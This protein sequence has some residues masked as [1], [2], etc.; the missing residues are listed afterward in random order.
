M[1]ATSAMALGRFE[2]LPLQRTSSAP[3]VSYSGPAAQSICCRSPYSRSAASAKAMSCCLSCP[4]MSPHL[5]A[6]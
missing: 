4:I 3:G 6:I 5:T 1:G 2:Y